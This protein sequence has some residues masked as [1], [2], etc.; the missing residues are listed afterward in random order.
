MQAHLKSGV[1]KCLKIIIIR[2][3]GGG[4][5]LMEKTILN[6]HFDYLNPPPNEQTIQAN[7][8]QRQKTVLAPQ[9]R[10]G[11]SA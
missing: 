8:G 5:R 1:K 9:V 4:G 6:F 3:R 11:H 10:E 7:T 2:G